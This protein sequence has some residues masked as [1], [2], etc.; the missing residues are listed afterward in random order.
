MNNAFLRVGL[1]AAAML[2]FGCGEYSEYVE[3]APAVEKK[4]IPVPPE[5]Q[6]E[7]AA[8]TA[9]IKHRHSGALPEISPEHAKIHTR[10]GIIYY[11]I[12]DDEKAE[13]NLKRA[14]NM[15]GTN[16]QAHLFYGRLLMREKKF[17]NA[18]GEFE[19][20]DQTDP[21]SPEV[22]KEMAGAYRAL[23]MIS[24]A[25]E[26]ERTPDESHASAP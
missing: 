11:T 26:M 4:E 18:L 1:V 10:L 5:Y 21:G 24:K 13:E 15:D 25:E 2:L 3:P 14:V 12:G 23:G 7:V 6:E 8:L 19:D 17:D 16:S 22:R 20:A 9:E